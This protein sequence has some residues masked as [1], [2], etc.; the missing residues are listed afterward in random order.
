V[1][2]YRRRGIGERFLYAAQWLGESQADADAF[3]KKE[4]LPALKYY[5]AYYSQVYHI[6]L[7]GSFIAST[8]AKQGDYVALDWENGIAVFSRHIF[9]KKY[10]EVRKPVLVGNNLAQE[11]RLI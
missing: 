10:V 3:A 9:E 2:K 8:V 5:K 4:G 7:K 1:K 11:G 6:R